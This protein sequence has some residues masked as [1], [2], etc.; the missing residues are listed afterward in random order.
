M[1]YIKNWRDTLARSLRDVLRIKQPFAVVLIYTSSSIY[2]NILQLRFNS[3]DIYLSR[4]KPAQPDISIR[5]Y[6]SY[7]ISVLNYLVATL[8]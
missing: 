3:I 2:I 4:L 8:N 1:N 7:L 5:D 6:L